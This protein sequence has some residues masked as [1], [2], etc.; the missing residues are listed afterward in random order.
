MARQRV[1]FYWVGES[2]YLNYTQNGKR[3]RPSLGKVSE[4][5]AETARQ[6]KEFELRTGQ[7]ILATG[8]RFGDFV[9]EYLAWHYQ[10]FPDSHDRIA[11]I[12][13]DRFMAFKNTPLD[14]ITPYDIE[15]WQTQRTR[16]TVDRLLGYAW[17]PNG[18]GRHRMEPVKKKQPVAKATILKE[19]RALSALFNRAVIWG[20]AKQNPVKLVE[21]PKDR[22]EKPVVWYTKAELER[23]YAV[24]KERAHWWRL[25]ANT[26]LRSAEARH[27]KWDDIRE[28]RLHVLSREGARTKS[29]HWRQVPLSRG[30]EAALAALRAANGKAEYVLPPMD[31]KSLSRACKKDLKRA[32]LGGSLHC[33]RHTFGATLVSASVPLREIQELMGHAS[34]KTTEIY[35]HLAPE[36]LEAAVTRLEL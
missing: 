33:L 5:E 23:L 28:K 10:K 6:A 32:G 19:L 29:G 15:M 7:K 35:A 13:S 9:I 12:L 36:N 2:A 11:Q 24:S 26:G 30:A 3:H 16:D 14:A 8:K 4:Q 20:L 22:K 34:M 1:T 17:V 21:K 18:R 27:L 31:P 25:M